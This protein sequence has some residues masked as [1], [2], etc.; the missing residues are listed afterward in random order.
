VICM[1][2]GPMRACF[3]CLVMLLIKMFSR[4]RHPSL[5]GEGGGGGGGVFTL[6]G[7]IVRGCLCSLLVQL[8][9]ARLRIFDCGVACCVRVVFVFHSCCVRVAFVL[10]F[11]LS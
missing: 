7:E 4:L 6:D 1:R 8:A 5:G 11:I 3:A 10:R 9:R 2:A